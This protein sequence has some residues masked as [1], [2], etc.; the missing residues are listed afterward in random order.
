MQNIYDEVYLWPRPLIIQEAAE[1]KT[2]CD[3]PVRVAEMDRN[4]D[5]QNKTKMYPRCII[6]RVGCPD[7]GKPARLE[8]KDTQGEPALRWCARLQ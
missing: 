2:S 8:S 5:D 4:S 1:G 7:Y 3:T 6:L